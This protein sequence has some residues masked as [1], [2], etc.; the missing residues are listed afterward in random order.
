MLFKKRKAGS[1]VIAQGWD[2]RAMAYLKDQ[3]SLE[4]T[5][6]SVT[7][8]R[9]FGATGEGMMGEMYEPDG[10]HITSGIL[11]NMRNLNFFW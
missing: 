8:R 11:A 4:V 7:K 1:E 2:D 10:Y 9:G 3:D 5:I 6:T